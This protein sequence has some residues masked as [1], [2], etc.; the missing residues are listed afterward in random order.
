MVGGKLQHPVFTLSCFDKT[1][2]SLCLHA[3]IFV[4]TDAPEALQEPPGC[5]SFSASRC[6]G[7]RS[8][9]AAL[10]KRLAA[11]TFSCVLAEFSLS[12]FSLSNL[13]TFF[14]YSLILSCKA[15]NCQITVEIS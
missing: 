8:G 1:F 14:S 13:L 6:I 4:Q 5:T 3:N 9:M 7:V 10:I 2:Y 12:H 15:S 11:A